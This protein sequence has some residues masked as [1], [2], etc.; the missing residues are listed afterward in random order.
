MVD[1]GD[2]ELENKI[3]T[4]VSIIAGVVVTQNYNKDKG[5]VELIG[6]SVIAFLIFYLIFKLAVKG[7]EVVSALVYPLAAPFNFLSNRAYKSKILTKFT[8]FCENF[9]KKRVGFG[10][11]FLLILSIWY[12]VFRWS[13]LNWVSNSMLSVIFGY[14]LIYNT[15]I[16]MKK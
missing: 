12:V 6:F 7:L 2:S 14:A 8:K 1:N 4:I 16:F 9:W 13:K 10:I 11:I 3:I 5:W 15:I